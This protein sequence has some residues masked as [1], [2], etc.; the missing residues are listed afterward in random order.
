M[1]V[2]VGWLTALVVVAGLAWRTVR[3][4]QGRPL[5]GDEAALAASLITR[6]FAGL[7]RPPLEYHQIA[8]LGFLWAEL[9]AARAFGLNE[10]SQRVVAFLCGTAAFL[11]FVRFARRAT[12]SLTALLAIAILAAA[13]Y[14]VRHTVELK[15]YAGDMLVAVAA[16]ALAWRASRG[17]ASPWPWAGLALLAA[18]GVWLS[19][20]AVFVIAGAIAFLGW[21]A[22]QTRSWRRFW[23][24]AAVACVFAASFAAAYVL[25]LRPL[26]EASPHYFEEEGTQWAAAFPPWEKPWLLPLWLLEVHTGNML[27]YPYGGNHFGSAATTLLVIVGAVTFWRGG[28]RDILALLLAPLALALAAACL[29]RYPYGSSARTMLYMAPSFCLLAGEGLRAIL[30]LLAPKRLRSSV[31]R[32][33]A[34]ALTGAILVSL[35]HDLARPYKDRLAQEV[36]QFVRDQAGR[37]RPGDQWIVPNS[38]APGHAGRALDARC[39]GVFEYY[40]A[41]LAPVPLRWGLTPE[42]V[43]PADGRTLVL[44]YAAPQ[45]D[46]NIPVEQADF[47][48]RLAG[49]LGP[50]A[51]ERTRLLRHEGEADP[52]TVTV[53]TFPGR[54]AK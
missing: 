29:R 20:P 48:R 33:A 45:R 46:P 25:Y 47:C 37:A 6:D 34:L 8:P 11:V 44:C 17:P 22:I 38:V 43:P 16:M 51:P 35:G 27:A 7:A 9:A 19:F 54:A 3:F 13:F 32:A 53:F 15:Q 28:R 39:D 31:V 52:V 21:K 41:A 30:R 2:R 5:W 24:V 23:G 4:A 1:V 26:A 40:L 50:S 14:P 49:R 10:W 12:D 18:V 42:Q 36:R